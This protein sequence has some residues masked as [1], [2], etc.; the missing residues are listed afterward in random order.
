[1]IIKTNMTL[2]AK[3]ENIIKKKKKRKENTRYKTNQINLA[4]GVW[5]K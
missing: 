1:M 2:S 5:F 3:E 4:F